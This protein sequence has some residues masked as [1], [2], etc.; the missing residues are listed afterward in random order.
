MNTDLLAWFCREGDP[1]V[2]LLLPTVVQRACGHK[3]AQRCWDDWAEVITAY[4]STLVQN[5]VLII[6]RHPERTMSLLSF[7]Y[8]LALSIF[9]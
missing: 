5:I 9:F 7:E 4:S 8:P 1:A 6:L 3:G 2:G